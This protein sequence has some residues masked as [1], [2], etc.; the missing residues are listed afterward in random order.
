MC[1]VQHDLPHYSNPPL[2]KVNLAGT[3]L[4]TGHDRSLRRG[5]N[6][7]VPAAKLPTARCFR[8]RAT[9]RERSL[10]PL[11]PPLHVPCPIPR[12][13]FAI[14]ITDR[15]VG[16]SVHVVVDNKYVFES[17]ICQSKLFQNKCTDETFAFLCWYTS[18]VGSRAKTTSTPGRKP[19]IW[20]IYLSFIGHL[21]TRD[22]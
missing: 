20:Q 14:N 11:T 18:Y 17:N 19:E 13:H 21:L 5:R 15:S 3:R 22:D 7:A 1:W 10:S 12:Q 4:Q 9:L 6:H 2:P 8:G 16:V